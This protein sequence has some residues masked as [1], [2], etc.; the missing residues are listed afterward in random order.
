[1]T[2]AI[3]G[4]LTL[5]LIVPTKATVAR[6]RLGP[7]LSV[8]R[9][10]LRKCPPCSFAVYSFWRVCCVRYDTAMEW[11]A[12]LGQTKIARRVICSEVQSRSGEWL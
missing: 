12:R 7:L 1:M 10:Y 4:G 6:S 5:C 9:A 3:N 8:G 11:L 2:Q